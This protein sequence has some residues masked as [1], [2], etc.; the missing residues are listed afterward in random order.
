MNPQKNESIGVKSGD[1]AGH[2][3]RSPARPIQRFGKLVDRISRVLMA[4]WPG[5]PSRR[6][7]DSSNP[8]FDRRKGKTYNNKTSI[9][10]SLHLESWTSW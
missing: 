8:S 7:I 10:Q 9:R 6:K 4:K 2:S 3:V 5:A 1:L